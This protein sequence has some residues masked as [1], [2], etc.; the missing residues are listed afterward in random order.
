MTMFYFSAQ[1]VFAQAVEVAQTATEQISQPAAMDSAQKFIDQLGSG[2]ALTIAIFLIELI[3][4]TMKTQNPKSLLYVVG[5]VLKMIA[6][7]CD[8]L[9]GALDKV[10]QR[11]KDQESG[12]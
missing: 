2:W 7:V 4:R 8:F 6:K 3:M 11:I 1:A 12:K 5:N 9:A 10:L